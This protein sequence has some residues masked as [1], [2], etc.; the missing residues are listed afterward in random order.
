[1]RQMPH[2]LHFFKAHTHLTYKGND[3]SVSYWFS[4][5]LC[6]F[7][8]PHLSSLS[9]FTP[10]GLSTPSSYFFSLCCQTQIYSACDA[11]RAEECEQAG[12]QARRVSSRKVCVH[13]CTIRDKIMA[14]RGLVWPCTR[15]IKRPLQVPRSTLMSIFW[16]LILNTEHPPSFPL[17]STSNLSMHT[18]TDT[19]Q[20]PWTY[21]LSCRMEGCV[22]AN[23]RCLHASHQTYLQE[24]RCTGHYE[25]AR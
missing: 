10:Q 9:P 19:I 5:A 3:T 2:R 18:N 21:L 12:R 22:T 8:L 14:P 11:C 20:T 7:S 24:S 25:G 17:F 16:G 4:S 6:M 23:K 1:M 15:S 13:V